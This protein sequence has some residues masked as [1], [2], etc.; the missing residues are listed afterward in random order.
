MS[1]TLIG[2]IVIETNE[3]LEKLQKEY[4]N[5]IENGIRTGKIKGKKDIISFQKFVENKKE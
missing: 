5:Y 3:E 2:S 4:S 1:K